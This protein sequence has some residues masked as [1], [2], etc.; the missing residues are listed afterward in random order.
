MLEVYAL[1]ALIRAS[2]DGVRKLAV[3]CQQLLQA[4]VRGVAGCSNLR[5]LKILDPTSG[6][7]KL[8]EAVLD[9]EAELAALAGLV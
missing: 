7:R 3:P 8:T 5:R 2:K 1:L 9:Q 6:I 4:S